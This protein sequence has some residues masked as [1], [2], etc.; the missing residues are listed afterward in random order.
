MLNIVLIINIIYFLLILSFYIYPPESQE[1][2]RGAN[3]YGK[4]LPWPAF[5]HA[6]ILLFACNFN[7][8]VI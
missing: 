5:G 7:R 8:D 1:S 3:T 2:D 4:Q 6:K